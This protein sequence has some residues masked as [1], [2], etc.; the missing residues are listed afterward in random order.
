M[1]AKLGCDC[2]EGGYSCKLINIVEFFL[3]QIENQLI[4]IPHLIL[5]LTLSL[6]LNNNYIKKPITYCLIT[7]IS[8]RL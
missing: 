8:S 2:A 7:V 6:N 4:N 1:S 3:G 5:L